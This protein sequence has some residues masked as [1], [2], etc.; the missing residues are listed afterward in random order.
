[1]FLNLKNKND[2]RDDFATFHFDVL[3]IEVFIGEKYFCLEELQF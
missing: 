3:K 2:D 1:M